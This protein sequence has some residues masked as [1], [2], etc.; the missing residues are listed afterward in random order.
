VAS[1]VS[2]QLITPDGSSVNYSL[3]RITTA[4]AVLIITN[5]IVQTPA[6]SYT[7]AGN[8]LTFVEAP[9]ES[10]IIDVRFL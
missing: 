1:D 7:V 9:L 3:D 10:D 4:A 6:V 2:A 5:G 8:V